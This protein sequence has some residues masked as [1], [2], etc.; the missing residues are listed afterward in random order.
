MEQFLKKLAAEIQAAFTRTS[1]LSHDSKRIPSKE[2]FRALSDE[3]IQESLEEHFNCPQGTVEA[4]YSG[5]TDRIR[6]RGSRLKSFKVLEYLVDFS[7]SRCSIPVAIWDPDTNP[8]DHPENEKFELLFTAESELGT[9]NEVCR[10]LL[11]LLDTRSQIRCLL[12]RKRRREAECDDLKK[13]LLDVLRRHAHFEDT[14][15]GWLFVA[16]EKDKS[17]VNCVVYTLALDPEELG[18]IQIPPPP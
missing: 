18:F 1:D 6:R 8:E 12:F 15:K 3:Q 13:R 5:C 7:F 17:K 4:R 2:I 11:K 9:P 16:L 14:R 10:D